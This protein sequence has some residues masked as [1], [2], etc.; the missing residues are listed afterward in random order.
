MAEVNTGPTDVEEGRS[1]WQKYG[2]RGLA[3]AL[4]FFLLFELPL[5]LAASWRSGCF[6]TCNGRSQP[7]A[8]AQPVAGR[9]E[10]LR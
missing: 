3:V 7:R 1:L 5:L 6:G 9:L 4:L 8:V 10:P 2:R